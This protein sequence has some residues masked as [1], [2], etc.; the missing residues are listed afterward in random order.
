VSDFSRTVAPDG[1]FKDALLAEIRKTKMAFYGTVIAQAQR[2]EVAG[3]RVTVTFGPNQRALR[4]MFEQNRPWLETIAQ[5]VAG[6]RIVVAAAQTDAAAAPA[7]GSQPPAVDK[8]SADRK[9][10][11]RE[12]ALADAG[13]QAMLEVFPAEIR[14]VEEM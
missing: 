5:Q 6:R 14:D 2:I 9:T 3:D 10:A 12:Q 1:N 7:E 8:K 11:L 13:V 4:D